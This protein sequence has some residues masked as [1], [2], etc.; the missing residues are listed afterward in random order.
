[1]D[2]IPPEPYTSAEGNLV[3]AVSCREESDHFLSLTRLKVNAKSAIDGG[4]GAKAGLVFLSADDLAGA[5]FKEEMSKYDSW[6]EED[7]TAMKRVEGEGADRLPI[8]YF[9]VDQDR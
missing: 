6:T 3:V 1:M 7:Y 2:V 4:S 9:E 5:K 8:A